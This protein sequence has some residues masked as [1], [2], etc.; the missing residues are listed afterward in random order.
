MMV[1]NLYPGRSGEMWLSH[2]ATQ[3]LIKYIS[4]RFARS[5]GNNIGSI[6]LTDG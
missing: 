4:V 6:K 2:P 1:R 5:D 3:K